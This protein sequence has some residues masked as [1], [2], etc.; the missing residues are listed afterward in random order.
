MDQIKPYNIYQL[1]HGHSKHDG[2]NVGQVSNGSYQ[3]I[4]AVTVEQ[5][6]DEP[7]FVVTAEACATNPATKMLLMQNSVL[8]RFLALLVVAIRCN[9][10]S[11]PIR[12]ADCLRSE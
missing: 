4:I 12:V 3:R 10:M 8:P 7:Y 5:V 2:Y 9:A 11:C 1:D 6:P